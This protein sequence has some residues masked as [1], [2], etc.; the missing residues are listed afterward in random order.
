M[1]RDWWNGLH[2]AA[3]IALF[4]AACLQA[5][6]GRDLRVTLGLAVV[7][8]GVIA[9]CGVL[10]SNMRLLLWIHL[11]GMPGLLA[12]FVL[13]GYEQTRVWAAAWSWG[14][15]EAGR[16]VLRVEGLFLANVAL[17]GT[18]SMRELAALASHRWIPRPAA[19][20]L[21]TAVRFIPITIAEARRIYEVQRCRGLRLRPWRPR[22][23]LPVMVPLFVG[24]MCRA[25]ETTLMLTVRRIVPGAAAGARRRLGALDWAVLALVLCG[26]GVALWFRIEQGG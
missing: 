10:R 5:V 16:Y 1:R 3:R 22:T 12:V 13:A 17:I 14:L 4:L 6:L 8:L 26:G 20:I 25:H 18:T 15:V 23:W 21:S 9:A 7:L 19:V 11:V 24:Q 2:P